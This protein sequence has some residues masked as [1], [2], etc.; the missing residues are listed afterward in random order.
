[1]QLAEPGHVS[2]RRALRTNSLLKGAGHKV[3]ASNRMV[4]AGAARAAG[5][6][7]G[8]AASST[9]GPSEPRIVAK[10]DGSFRAKSSGRKPVSPT[11]PKP[12]TRLLRAPSAVARQPLQVSSGTSS[13]SVLAA[14]ASTDQEISKAEENGHASLEVDPM[15]HYVGVYKGLFG[16]KRIIRL[17]RAAA[18]RSIG[19]AP[20]S[21]SGADGGGGWRE[22]PRRRRLAR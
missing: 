12:P 21:E 5:D 17:A 20:G 3:L 4:K 11:A 2:Q 18:D 1:M 22:Q 16:Q 6:V 14:V 7:A 8:V 9:A 19:Q 15:A 10:P 13:A